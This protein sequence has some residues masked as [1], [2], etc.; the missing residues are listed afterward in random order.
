MRLA[1]TG[2]LGT[3][4][5]PILRDPVVVKDVDV[6]ITE[7][8]YGNRVHDPVE[9]LEE[10]FADV[11][12]R[13]VSRGGKIIIP[14]FSVGRTQH[15]VFLLH[16]LSL[17]EKIPH[18]PVFV[19]SP[20]SANATEIF[21]MHSECYD[22]DA[23][24]LLEQSGSE[25][26]FGRSMGFE[27]IQYIRDVEESKALNDRKKPCV[28]ISASGM[29]EVGRILHHLKINIENERNTVMIVGF[30]AEHTLGKRLVEHE[31]RVKIFGEKYNVNAEVVVFNALSAHADKN[32]LMEYF[33]AM[34]GHIGKA[35]VVHG[36]EDQSLALADHMRELDIGEVIVPEMGQ[37]FDV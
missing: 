1:F 5:V 24:E 32:G 9:R 10:K 28:I 27:R 4:N 18:V 26:I 22:E 31:P 21:K 14:A 25:G 35:F 29:C 11:V 34:N 12:K 30:M 37:S 7:S 2:D 13:T 16:K 8:T 20:L 6:L 15:V 3:Q 19:D 36:A 33:K 17:E 23:R